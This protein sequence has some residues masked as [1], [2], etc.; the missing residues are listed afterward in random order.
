[1]KQNI[2]KMG[3]VQILE[4]VLY[5]NYSNVKENG[6]VC[7]NLRTENV[8]MY[9]AQSSCIY[10]EETEFKVAETKLASSF[11]DSQF[12]EGMRKPYRLDA[13]AKKVA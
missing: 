7:V 3:D 9:A 10:K 4:K 11:H 2:P 5:V 8:R 13:S 12:L 6:E 1:M